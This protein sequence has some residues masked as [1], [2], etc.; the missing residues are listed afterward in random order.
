MGANFTESYGACLN[1]LV[2]MLPLGIC[3]LIFSG[4]FNRL[5]LLCDC[6][7]RENLGKFIFRLNESFLN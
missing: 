6:R 7:W 3:I 5:L 4:F 2:H 1:V